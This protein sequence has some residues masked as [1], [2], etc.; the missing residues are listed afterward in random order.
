MI[1][2]NSHSLEVDHPFI[3][4]NGNVSQ[5]TE[6][7][8]QL[9]DNNQHC[10][11]EDYQQ[12]FNDFTKRRKPAP[13][14]EMIQLT[15]TLPKDKKISLAVG[16]PNPETFPIVELNVKLNDGSSFAI[17]GTAMQDALQYLPS[18]GYG[19]LLKLLQQWQD[20]IHGKQPWDERRI[21]VTSGSQEGIKLTVDCFMSEKDPVIIQYPG[22]AGAVDLFKPYQ[23][24]F[25]LAEQ[26]ED[27]IIPELLNEKLKK[28]LKEGKTM[29]KLFYVN[30]TGA[31]P[32]GTTLT[33]ERT[34]KLYSM[35][36][37]YNLIIIEDDPYYFIDFGQEYRQSFLSLDTTGRVLRFDTFSKIF[38]PG[39]RIGYITG[40][41]E[42]LR[43]IELNLQCSSLH[44]SSL[45]QAVV[46]NIMEQ[47]GQEKALQELEK[48][49]QFYLVRR[50][51]ML[52][53]AE[54][55]LKDL[56]DWS[57]PKGGMFLWIRVKKLRSIRNLVIKRCLKKYLA[58]TPGYV[59]LEDDKK[60]CPHI[61]L[62]F[63]IESPENISKGIQIL[64]EAIREEITEQS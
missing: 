52:R 23:A 35:A 31:N 11:A 47:W 54:K 14:R 34:L 39:M 5:E 50:D 19:P 46:Y 1:N 7:F 40:P 26:D 53:V 45:S 48:I 27:G 57:V 8:Q 24:D 61:R 58:L 28:R 49:K 25:I 59:F 63:A 20:K 56:A 16:C 37:A 13:L 9:H 55:H 64:A 51:Y 36:C 2:G 10:T 21:L 33:N 32:T 41:N 22:Y 60:P 3:A 43:T 4:H 38:S 6:K 30:P 42:L 62:S 18:S 29:P 15:S 44:C 12:F 17:N